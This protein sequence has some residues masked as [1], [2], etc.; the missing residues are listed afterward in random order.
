MSKVSEDLERKLK[1]YQYGCL[2]LGMFVIFLVG[3]I[4]G[5]TGWL[6]GAA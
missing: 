3:I 6:I 5:S 4:M 2:L 1:L